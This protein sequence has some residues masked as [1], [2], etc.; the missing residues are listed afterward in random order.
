MNTCPTIRSSTCCP[1]DNANI[2]GYKVG[3]NTTPPPPVIT[4]PSNFNAWTTDGEYIIPDFTQSVEICAAC[5]EREDLTITQE[6]PAGT[7]ITALGGVIIV[8]TVTD[9]YGQTATCSFTITINEPPNDSGGGGGGGGTIP[10][11]PPW[12]Y[13]PYLF[14]YWSANDTLCDPDVVDEG[15]PCFRRTDL[16]RYFGNASPHDLT[17]GGGGLYSTVETP[18]DGFPAS[19]GPIFHRGSFYS[20]NA[21]NGYFYHA[22]GT[23]IR[24]LGTSFTMQT[25]FKLVALD[26]ME[27]W[28]VA[29]KFSGLG[30]RILVRRPDS[31][32]TYTVTAELDNGTE[33][34]TIPAQPF[35][36]EDW[37]YVVMVFDA[38]LGQLRLYI[39]GIPVGMDTSA[40]FTLVG[41][42]SQFRIGS[43]T[44]GATDVLSCWNLNDTSW[45]DS[46]GGRHLTETGTINSVA[47][48]LGNA[49]SFPITTGGK[50]SYAADTDL[51]LV[52]TDF[53]IRAWMRVPSAL[54]NPGQII[55]RHSSAVG[56]RLR[57]TGPNAPYQLDF[58]LEAATLAAASTLAANTWYHVVVTY[59]LST[60]ALRIYLNAAL[61][62]SGVVAAQTLAAANFFI[63]PESNFVGPVEIDEVAIF[64]KELSGAEITA[65]Y[66]GGTGTGCTTT[67]STAEI[68]TDEIGIW[69]QA[70]SDARVAEQ[71]A[72]MQPYLT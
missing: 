44:A 17:N 38:T 52:G 59:K 46:V 42:A 37:I 60:Q 39:D 30:Y 53:S 62:N 56:W 20:N 1:S 48:K 40:G 71:Y 69:L 29:G 36:L 26:P 13:A 22:D 14:A 16:S 3:D 9:T 34:L 70:W 24:L 7:V 64:T 32:A 58:N 65:D 50:L 67:P 23:A 27:S 61:D 6:P 47:G 63:G 25:F 10:T 11:L 66:N 45:E 31:S 5:Q 43:G 55:G 54:S 21:S 8:I 72:I 19:P 51:G 2:Y 18:L 28:Q 33:I 49:A 68:Y 35:T 57:I 41:E 15:F 4:C 12:I